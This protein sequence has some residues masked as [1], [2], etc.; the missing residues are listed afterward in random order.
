MESDALADATFGWQAGAPEELN[1]A[2]PWL[3]REKEW[4]K[5]KHVWCDLHLVN[6]RKRKALIWQQS[7][8]RKTSLNPS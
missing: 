2:C 6:A 1:R 3:M 4:A 5:W 8:A 7:K